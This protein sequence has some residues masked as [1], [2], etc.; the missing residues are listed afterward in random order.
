MD[1]LGVK[2]MNLLKSTFKV[3]FRSVL[4][5]I[6]GMAKARIDTTTTLTLFSVA[7]LG[8][9][10]FTST[11]AQAGVFST[12]HF[13]PQ[14]NYA[15][16]LEP[17]VLLSS[18]GGLGINLRYTHGISDSTNLTGIFGTG[19]GSRGVRFGG[20]ASFDLF[21]DVEKQPG[22]GVA[23][24]ALLIQLPKALAFEATGVPYI[25]K[26]FPVVKAAALHAIEPF[27][28]IPIGVQLSEGNYQLLTSLSLGALFEH[29]A[30]FRS[31]FEVGVGLASASGTT[32]SGGIVYYN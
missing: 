32:L 6:G 7:S 25:H 13:V 24:Q 4:I 22:I 29:S 5:K 2:T 31:V 19:S 28:A 12:P 30:H 27:L 1:E 20:L 10:L 15:L 18:G 23:V 3:N 9:G 11:L 17:E 21:P 14:D 8:L 26:S 16:G